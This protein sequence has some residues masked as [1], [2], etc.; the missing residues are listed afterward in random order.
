M[1]YLIIVGKPI[2]NMMYNNMQ[3]HTIPEAVD[4]KLDHN[5][6]H[7]LV[8]EV[9]EKQQHL[10]SIEPNPEADSDTAVH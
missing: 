9:E 3:K 7:N 5:H 2:N 6:D 4:L 10:A 8:L 1:F